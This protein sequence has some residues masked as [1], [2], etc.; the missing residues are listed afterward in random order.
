MTTASGSSALKTVLIVIAAL[1]IG[2]GA[3]YIYNEQN[4]ESVSL[5]LPGGNEITVEKSE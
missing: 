2:A 1:V 4:K 5:Q 3:M